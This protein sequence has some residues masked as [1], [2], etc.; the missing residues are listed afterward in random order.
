MN[1]VIAC[2]GSP[3]L[4]MHLSPL[5][6][7]FF[8]FVYD[9]VLLGMTSIF[10]TSFVGYFFDDVKF[11]ISFLGD[12]VSGNPKVRSAPSFAYCSEFCFCRL[13]LEAG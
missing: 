3:G 13:S 10:L 4:P 2:F 7:S 11:R 12:T 6:S 9:R 8:G 5:C 1:A